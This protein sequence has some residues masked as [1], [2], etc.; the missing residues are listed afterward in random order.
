MYSFMPRQV[1]VLKFGKTGTV[2]LNQPSCIQTENVN[3][4]SNSMT[5]LM[6]ARYLVRKNSNLGMLQG[7][8]QIND[9]SDPSVTLNSCVF[10]QIIVNCN[11]KN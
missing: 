8:F 4:R 1:S 7:D 5:R 6:K 11:K 3:P 2:T 9:I 10:S